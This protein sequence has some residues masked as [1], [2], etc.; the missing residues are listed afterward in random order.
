[1]SAFD[2]NP[3]AVSF[4]VT[5]EKH[6]FYSLKFKFC[7]KFRRRNSIQF[8]INPDD[9]FIIDILKFKQKNEIWIV[10]I[11]QDPSVQQAV[12]GTGTKQANLE[13]YNPFD[14]QK[15]QT[16]SANNAGKWRNRKITLKLF[17][18]IIDNS[19]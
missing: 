5:S 18:I 14:A 9:S 8:V 13:D 4:I 1:M 15:N 6:F 16:T 11:L 2:E 3:F 17:A 12:E 7:F 19:I 10:L